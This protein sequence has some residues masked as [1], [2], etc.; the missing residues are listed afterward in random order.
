MLLSLA[1]LTTS[2]FA[3]A[4]PGSGFDAHG[5]RLAAHDADPRDPLVG[6]RAGRFERFSW[7]AGGVFEYASEPLVFRGPDGDEVELDNLVTANLSAGFAPHERVRIDFGMPI[8]FFA[9]GRDGLMGEGLGDL[10]ATGMISIIRPGLRTGGLGLAVV[11]DLDLPTGDAQKWLGYTTVAGGAGLALTYEL[12]K[13]TLSTSASTQLRPTVDPTLRPAP[14]KG[15]SAFVW[16]A[17]LGY[18]VTPL[19]GVTVELNGEVATDE[20]VRRAIGIPVEATLS[21]KHTTEF[22]GFLTAGLGVGLSRGAGASPLRLLVGGGFGK[23]NR[24]PPDMDGDGFPDLEDNCPATAETINGYRDEDGCPDHLPEM[25]FRAIGIDGAPSSKANLIV[26]GPE[27][28]E[29]LGELRFQGDT[30]V[31]GSQWSVYATEGEC[32]VGRGTITMGPHGDV[33]DVALQ[34]NRSAVLQVEVIGPEGPV[35]GATVELQADDAACVPEGAVALEGGVG[36]VSVGPGE[37]WAVIAAPGMAPVKKKVVIPPSGAETLRVT[38]EPTLAEIVVSDTGEQIIQIAEKV[39][40]D[41]G[42]ATIQ[43][44]SFDLLDNV[45]SVIL[46]HDL[47]R[48]LIGGH[49]DDRGAAEAN[50]I[51]SQKRAEAVLQYLVGKGVSESQLFARG[52]GETQPIAENTTRSGRAKNRRVEFV[53]EV[54]DE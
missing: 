49:T 44:R 12:D 34:P 48:V 35:D 43:S 25:V 10:R 22:G 51:L 21:M 8:I 39:Y 32:L 52:Y 6:W 7:M 19:T 26:S 45:A 14:T 16:G 13:L 28:G 31:P 38:L 20:A 53:V 18:L 4:P 30:V 33:I 54:E 50:Q 3:Q 17:S 27:Q 23:L 41:S 1:L 15:G 11:A 5:F 42:A 2:G 36:A 29:G 37:M 47:Q 9:E 40:F 46:F 24:P